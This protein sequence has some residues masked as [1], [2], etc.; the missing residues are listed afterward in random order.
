MVKQKRWALLTFHLSMIV[1]LLGAAITRYFGYE[2]IMH[3]REGGSSNS[4]LSA[5]TYLLFEVRKGER[6]YRFDEPVLFSSLGDND[7]KSS[8]LIGSD[9]IEVAV[10]EFIPNPKELIEESPMG[11]PIDQG[12]VRRHGRARGVLRWRR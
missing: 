6:T 3:I 8:Y 5:E 10:K 9:L 11:K 1:I 12:G 7:W 2:G 4:I